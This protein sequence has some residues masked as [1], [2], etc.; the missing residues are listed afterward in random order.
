MKSFP[1]ERLEASGLTESDLERVRAYVGE[2][3]NA[4][5]FTAAFSELAVLGGHPARELVRHPEWLADIVAGATERRDAARVASGID[6]RLPE[7]ASLEALYRE[8]R[9]TKRRESLRI[10]L[11]EVRGV[12]MRET[13][14]EIAGLAEACLD[15]AVRRLAM[16]RDEPEM[17]ES[18][19]IL[20]MGKLGGRELN[21]SSD[22]D[23]VYVCSNRA[24]N[25][26]E[27]RV[28]AADF[29][30]AVTDLFAA[31]TEDGYVF[32]VDLRLRPDGTQGPIVQPARAMVDYYLQFGHTWERSAMLKARPVAGARDLGDGVLRDLEPFVYRRYLDYGALEELRAMKAKIEANAEVRA[33]RGDDLA[34]EVT[35]PDDGR[36]PLADRLKS[37]MRMQGRRRR[38]PAA[39]QPSPTEPDVDQS[40]VLGWDLKI[41]VGGIREIEFFVQALQLVHGGTRPKL[42]VKNTLEAL[43]VLL[44]AGL[45]PNDV[46]ALLVDAYD[47]YRR[48]EHLIQMAEDRQ[49]HRMPMTWTAFD[50]LAKH[51]GFDR[52]ELRRTVLEHRSEVRTVFDRL[53]QAEERSGRDPTLEATPGPDVDLIV[54]AA[55]AQSGEPRIRAALVALGFRRPRQVAGQ[56]EILREKKWG[57]FR[58]TSWGPKLELARHIVKS[59]AAAPD[60]DRAFSNLSRFAQAVGDRP[61]YWSML[62]DN[63]HATRLLLQVFGSS[64]YLSSAL[65]RDPNVFERLLAVGTVAIEKNAPQLRRDLAR[66]LLG[67]EDPEHRLGIVRRFHRE[68]TLRIGLHET[69]GAARIEQTLEQ[70]S[71]LAEV[72]IEQV[73][74]E[75]YQP[76]RTRRRRP[77]SVLPPL[78]EIAFS[79]VAMGKLGGRELGFGSDLDVMF[80]Y[81]EDRQWKLEH[82]FFARLAQRLIWTLSS[83]SAE[84]KMYEVDTRLRP[85]GS[86]GALVVSLDA[87]ADYYKQNAGNWERQALIRS[88]PISG[89]SPLVAAIGELRDEVAFEPGADEETFG[90]VRSMR[91]RLDQAMY[92]HGSRDVKF[93]PGGLVD[94]EFAVQALQLRFGVS[95]EDPPARARELDAGIRSQSTRRAIV[96]FAESDVDVDMTGV[97]EAYMWLCR[98]QARL[99]M[100]GE[101][102]SSVLPGDDGALETL[103]RRM[104]HQGADATDSFLDRLET[105]MQRGRRLYEEVLN[106]DLPM[107]GTRGN[108]P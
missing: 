96:G 2:L 18:F 48:I 60:P 26:D 93:G 13:T 6:D 74:D 49:Y 34:D 14:A 105:T 44:W 67:I 35:T 42:R 10:L 9:Y 71:L 91:D 89:P 33:V 68:E 106:G 66:R 57:P 70:L 77:G 40:G 88:R 29:A 3:P 1:D 54:R 102:A 51:L 95:S 38:R 87:F 72:V 75:V 55:T 31:N 45:V 94:I 43:D 65:I 19:C 101:G 53:F 99:R 64:P 56:V 62:A 97:A 46:H 69:G 15:V 12:S 20:G 16:L 82:G 108:E 47:T 92:E 59:A 50:T 11:R 7:G 90:E 76:L 41:G 63:P 104:G 100:A 78:R 5:L 24:M 37:R 52:A 81:Q 30:R 73:V 27:F 17:A 84:G 79:V 25:D 36:A 80:V 28:R 23:L 21:F 32:R 107:T 8:L 86:R 85:S 22:V 83:A 103:A 58:E 61:G 4:E 39:V 98:T